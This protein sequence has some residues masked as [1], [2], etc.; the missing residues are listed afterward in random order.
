MCDPAHISEADGIDT[1]DADTFAIISPQTDIANVV[2]PSA[3]CATVRCPV[4]RAP[5][6]VRSFS[7]IHLGYHPFFLLQIFLLRFASIL[8]LHDFPRLFP[9]PAL[10]RHFIRSTHYCF[11]PSSTDFFND[12]PTRPL[13]PSSTSAPISLVPSS[14]GSV[15]HR[16]VSSIGFSDVPQTATLSKL[17]HSRRTG[18]SVPSRRLAR[19]SSPAYRIFEARYDGVI[20]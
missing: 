7:P 3:A 20:C 9:T 12:N 10:T 19:P 11:R 14:R 2:V 15:S 17:H 4:N 8:T 16:T 6:S 18:S 13:S 1:A 5:S